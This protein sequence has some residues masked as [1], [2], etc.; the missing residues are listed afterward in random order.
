MVLFITHQNVR[1]QRTFTGQKGYCHFDC[2]SMPVLRISS[3]KLLILYFFFQLMKEPILSAHAKV[4]YGKEAH[5]LKNEFSGKFKLYCCLTEEVLQREWWN[6]HDVP[7]VETVYPLTLIQIAENI[8]HVWHTTIVESWYRLLCCICMCWIS[9]VHSC[10]W[11]RN[12]AF[13]IWWNTS[14]SCFR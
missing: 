6:L 14:S 7:N 12:I 8:F 11:R 2:F 9:V 4:A 1:H 13:A 5:F 10:H 3:V